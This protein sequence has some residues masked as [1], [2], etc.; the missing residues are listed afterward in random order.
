MIKQSFIFGAVLTFLGS[1][2]HIAIIIGGPDWYLASGAGENMATLAKSDSMYPAFVGSILV[3]I[4]FGWS[5]YALSGAGIIRRLPF[6]K[7]FLILIAGLCI[8]R[9]LYGF[10]IPL[11]FN[12]PYVI[13][14]GVWF[15]VASSMVWL[16]IGLFYA[17][18]IRSR[19]SYISGVKT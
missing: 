6:L 18:G 13:N 14:L 1:L 10:F 16:V 11:L 19:W 5:L 4:F 12:T 7:L 8:V 3:C 2:L 15:W 9:G 17:A